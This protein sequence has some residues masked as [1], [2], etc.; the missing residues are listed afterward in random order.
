MSE[1]RLD[2]AFVDKLVSPEQS[3]RVLATQPLNGKLPGLPEN[4]VLGVM[5]ILKKPE[6]IRQAPRT[7]KKKT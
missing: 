7:K 2:S 5:E 3:G 1:T 4:M 6:P